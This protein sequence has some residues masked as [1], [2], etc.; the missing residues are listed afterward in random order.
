MKLPF[1]TTKEILD[2]EALYLAGLSE[3]YQR[4]EPVIIDLKK[5]VKERQTRQTPGGYLL[6]AELRSMAEWKF[7]YLPS[8]ID[9]NLPACIEEVTTAAFRLNDDWEKLKKLI[10]LYGVGQSVASVILHFYDK[11]K[12]PILD[13]HALRSVGIKEECVYGPEYPFWQEYVDFCR[14][15]AECYNVSMRTLDRA[16]WKY[17]ASGAAAALKV[18][19]DETLFLELERRGITSQKY[20]RIPKT[21][22][23][24]TSA[25]VMTSASD[26]FVSRC[27]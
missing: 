24:A 21:L 12:Y 18:I 17:S 7:H 19:A 9:K 14:A 2:W 25:V 27:S 8:K 16:L 6:K 23:R 26:I 13:H 15:E 11:K 10:G 1:T 5:K 20:L 4:L 22:R 3:K